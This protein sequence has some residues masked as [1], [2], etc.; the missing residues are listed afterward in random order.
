MKTKFYIFGMLCALTSAQLINNA[1]AGV[2]F[3]ESFAPLYTS[4]NDGA[5]SAT[6][7]P[8]ETKPVA[9]LGYDLRTTAGYKF[10]D[11]FLIGATLNYIR[12]PLHR[13][14]VAGGAPAQDLK[15][16]DLEFG[17]TVGYVFKG[18]HVSGTYFLTGK[19]TSID[20]VTDDTGTVTTDVKLEDKLDL[21]YQVKLGYNF[22][23]S[24]KV[25]FGPTLVYRYIKY[26]SQKGTDNLNP[27]SNYD[28]AY[29]TKRVSASIAPML[30]LAINF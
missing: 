26:K 22:Q 10:A 29:A 9:G 18:W 5:L 21:G 3:E 28:T 24:Q 8:A 17:P 25:S 6:P 13:D 30:S 4:E 20:K 1:H 2:Y 14:V 19:K 23:I 11:R 15:S 27:A 7:A 12:L 16:T